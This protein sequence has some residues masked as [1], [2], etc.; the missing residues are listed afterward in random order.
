MTILTPPGH[1]EGTRRE[2]AFTGNS[3]HGSEEPLQPAVT[4]PRARTIMERPT[5]E[6]ES[7]TPKLYPGG[8]S[9]AEAE[10]EQAS[11][12]PL[13]Q[14][15]DPAGWDHVTLVAF[16]EACKVSKEGITVVISEEMTGCNLMAILEDPEVH[17]ILEEDLG[18]TRKL[19]RLNMISTVSRLHKLYSV[20]KHLGSPVM[21]STGGSTGN[22]Q[23]KG[24]GSKQP[25]SLL[26]GERAIT[27]PTIPKAPPG[28]V[29]PTAADWKIFCIDTQGWAQL[30]SHQ[31]AALVNQVYCNPETDDIVS[32]LYTK[33]TEEEKR[34]DSVLGVQLRSTASYEVKKL[35]T[36]PDHYQV[37]G[38]VSGLQI[39]AY[40]GT[41][42]NKK[43]ESRFLTIESKFV[44]REARSSIGEA[45]SSQVR[46]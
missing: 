19:S 44:N 4:E 23:G 2:L 41:K 42:I 3:Q 20:G 21:G 38:I 6:S 7:D 14:S 43:C 1:R 15:T 12:R 5:P 16:L 28:Q 27:I 46:R 31:Y 36:K 30:S 34:T 26:N 39:I 24:S 37:S 17:S 11:T 33:F 35:F 18:V 8:N 29:L 10:Y 40:M 9:T 32:A 13:W 45:T 22:S 25:S